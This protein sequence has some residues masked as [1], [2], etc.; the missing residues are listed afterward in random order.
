M[1]HTTK[2]TLRAILLMSGF[3]ESNARN[4]NNETFAY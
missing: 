1:S 2:D 3:K 4:G